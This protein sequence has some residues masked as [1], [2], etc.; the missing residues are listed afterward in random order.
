MFEFFVIYLLFFNLPTNSFCCLLMGVRVR[1]H[2]RKWRINFALNRNWLALVMLLELDWSLTLALSYYRNNR[3]VITGWALS[4][5][6]G[7]GDVEVGLY[8]V[9]MYLFL[10][11]IFAAEVGLGEEFNVYVIVVV[12]GRRL[13]VLGWSLAGRYLSSPFR[14]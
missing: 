11:R 12:C 7:R 2:V 8:G 9:Y 1:V 4:E 13:A 14:A 10:K 6:W 3:G 5:G